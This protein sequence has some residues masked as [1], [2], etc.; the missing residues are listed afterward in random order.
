[1]P[2][3]SLHYYVVTSDSFSTDDVDI[4][5]RGGCNVSVKGQIVEAIALCD[6]PGLEILSLGGS[7]TNE[8][9]GCSRSTGSELLGKRWD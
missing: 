7:S 9:A 1:M 4:H 3:V 2:M 8:C 6:D 5:Q